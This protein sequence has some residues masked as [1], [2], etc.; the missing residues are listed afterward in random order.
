M[1]F[2]WRNIFPTVDLKHF[3]FHVLL[4]IILNVFSFLLLSYSYDWFQ[5]ESSVTIVIYTKQKVNMLSETEGKQIVSRSWVYLYAGPF[6][7]SFKIFTCSFSTTAL[8]QKAIV[9]LFYKEGLIFSQK[10]CVWKLG[11]YSGYCLLDVLLPQMLCA[12]RL[13]LP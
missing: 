12:F 6:L 10:F 3:W 8:R 11:R 5:T 2:T 13:T 1:S 7:R 4:Y 9:S